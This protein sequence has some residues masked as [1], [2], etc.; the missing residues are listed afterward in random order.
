MGDG[1][2]DV[3]DDEWVEGS[4]ERFDGLVQVLLTVLEHEAELLLLVHHLAQL[5]QLRVLLEEQQGL[6]LPQAERVIERGAEALEA[7][8]G[9]HVAGREVRGL[10]HHAERA[11]ADDALD[12]VVLHRGRRWRRASCHR[13]C[14]GTRCHNDDSACCVCSCL[15]DRR[16]QAMEG[17][18][19]CERS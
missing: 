19:L 5:H 9:D 8:D 15:V 1:A 2:D 13:R 16:G 12:A 4:C 3:A 18:E 10:Q 14:V 17:K 7:L 11:V 6:H